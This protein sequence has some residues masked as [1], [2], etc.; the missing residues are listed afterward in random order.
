MTET[1][2]C[3]ACDQTFDKAWTDKDALEE[4][5]DL[6]GV[7]I[8]DEALLVVCDDCFKK[9]LENMKR[10]EEKATFFLRCISGHKDSRPAADCRGKDNPVCREPGCTMPM[11]LEKVVVRG[12]K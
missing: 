12:K 4:K 9:E 3:A 8:P 10:Q 2:T 6:W 5:N 1:F 11:V 7:V